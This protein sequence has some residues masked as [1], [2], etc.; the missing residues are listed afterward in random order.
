MKTLVNSILLFVVLQV[1][2]LRAQESIQSYTPDPSQLV[3]QRLEQWQDMKFGLLMHWGAYSQWG[4]V[5]SWSICAEDEDWCRRNTDNYELYK[6]NYENLKLSFNPVR[7]DPSIWAKAAKEAGMK[8]V[9]FTTKHHDG[10]C[11]YNS[12][13]TDYK[14]TDAA[15]PYHVNQRSDIAREVFDAFRAE[16]M[17]AGA[18]FSKPDWHNTDYWWPNFATPDRNVNYDINKYPERWERYVQYTHN[19]LMELVT[20]YGP[21]DLVWLDGG[22]VQKLSDEQVKKLSKDPQYRFQKIK[23]Q[24]IRMDELVGKLRSVKPDLIIVDRAVPG[25]NQNYLTPENT[26]PAHYLPY[27]W[28]S[29]IIAG[30]SWS[31][32]PEAKYL[33]P[34]K[35]IHTLCEIVAKGGNLLLNI[36]PGPDGTWDKDAY[37]M[38]EG[39]G[40]WMKLNGNAIYNTRAVS[41]YREGRL[42]WTQGKDGKR[43]AIYLPEESEKSLP[44]KVM[45]NEFFAK[46][47]TKITLNGDKTPLEFVTS[48]DGTVVIIPPVLRDYQKGSEAWV[49]CI[50]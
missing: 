7:F 29:C 44:P 5:E 9:V 6:K 2:S 10:F 12:S 17:W 15:C 35:V 27:P 13:Y 20:N 16:G 22:W 31:W 49:F 21:L 40:H 43:F 30:E 41:P 50:E 11:M 42:A 24:D 4:V 32:I 48:G 26:V 37:Q 25:K 28:E 39:V 38:L 8:Y 3:N 23:S 33:T 34:R 19:Q 36:A 1:T 47:S 14:V 46:S 18:Y 45:M